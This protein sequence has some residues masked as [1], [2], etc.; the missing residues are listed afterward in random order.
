MT[1][2]FK[3]LIV[4]GCLLFAIAAFLYVIPS[5]EY[6]LLPDEARP[7]APQ[8]FV[9]G[10]RAD[11]DGG[12]IYYVAV[13]I[14][15][16]SV[17]EKLFHGI[18]EGSTLVPA[19]TVRAPGE[20]DAE[21]RKVELRAMAESQKIG[22]AVALKS[23]G[24]PVRVKVLGTLIAGVDP[25]GP[26]NEKLQS[27]DSI[28]SVDGEA[29]KTLAEIRRAIRKHRPGET[30]EIGVRRD[31]KP[32]T[33]EVETVPEPKH[34]ER[35]IIGVFL[36][37]DSRISLPLPVRIDLGQV[38]GPSAGLAFALDVAEE[39]GHDIDRGHRVAASGELQLDGTVL[40]VGGLKQKTIGARQAGVDVFLVPA[41]ENAEDARR[42]AGSMK[43]VP[44]KSYRQALRALATLPEERAKS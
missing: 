8:V 23:L 1:R 30:V 42:Y 9:K 35:P 21:H 15:K 5:D 19:S 44:V 39:L 16:A 41:G 33:I 25:K 32:R 17:L 4:T 6:I 20:S 18:R 28:V 2:F 11:D 13:E 40:P 22:A 24:Y 26:S 36:Q 14:D 43:V 10:E 34:P 37:A 38:G 7:L 29:T 3:L 27:G 12:G 31:G